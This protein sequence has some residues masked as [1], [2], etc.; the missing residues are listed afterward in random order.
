MHWVAFKDHHEM[1][2]LLASESSCAA[3]PAAAESDS[4]PP[5]APRSMAASEAPLPSSLVAAAASWN[6]DGTS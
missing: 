3:D 4:R 5:R 2:S 6:A 1:I